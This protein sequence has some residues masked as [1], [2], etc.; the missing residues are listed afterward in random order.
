MDKVEKELNKA[1]L[2]DGADTTGTVESAQP[3][4][5][6]AAASKGEIGHT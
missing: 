1:T 2:A 4:D 6:P 5:N 3:Q